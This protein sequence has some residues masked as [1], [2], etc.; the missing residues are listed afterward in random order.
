MDNELVI[1]EDLPSKK[2]PLNAYNLNHNFDVY[3]KQIKEEAG[4]IDT[5][6]QEIETAK[7]NLESDITTKTGE[8]EKNI[9][10][11]TS[12]LQSEITTATEDLTQQ[13]SDSNTQLTEQITNSKTD[14]ET[15]INK[16]R[17]DL[18]VEI[19]KQIASISSLSI[20]IVDTLPTENVSE[21]TIY[22]ILPG[23]LPS[24]VE[25]SSDMVAN[26]Q[27]FQSTPTVKPQVFNVL[28]QPI[29]REMFVKNTV[30]SI[31]AVDN[32]GIPDD[33]YYIACFWVKTG[34]DTHKWVAVGNTKIDLSQY[35][36]TTEMN[37]AI[38]DKATE[39]IDQL[40]PLIPTK[41]SQLDNDSKYLTSYK[42]TDP[43]V[44]AHVK[45][46]TSQDI[47]SWNGKSTFSGNYSDLTG[48]PTIPRF[49]KAT[50]EDDAK[51]KSASDPNNIYYTVAE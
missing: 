37:K 35:S 19:G 51:S 24:M 7:T 33:E 10:D 46:I 43:T 15:Q 48:K 20:L 9:T 26:A 39:V 38:Q 13:I 27:S 14:L 6:L 40:T 41:V 8:L 1:F 50:S 28:G 12:Q 5:T 22:L 18:M 32:V 42:E 36:T 29:Y 11:A 34:E 21:T 17:E 47:T 49:I 16:A 23:N 25:A 44:P 30:A 2:T 3:N 4:K 45:A 31:Q